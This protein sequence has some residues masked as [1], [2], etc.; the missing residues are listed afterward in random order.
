VFIHAIEAHRRSFADAAEKTADETIR[1]HL[2][3]RCPTQ[4]Q[5]AGSKVSSNSSSS[6]MDENS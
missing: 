3:I 1:P 2:S 6:E 5:P 4:A